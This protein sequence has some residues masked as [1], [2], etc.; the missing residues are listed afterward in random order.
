MMEGCSVCACNENEIPSA[1][2][3]NNLGQLHDFGWVSSDVKGEGS[4]EFLERLNMSLSTSLPGEEVD[5]YLAYL[6]AMDDESK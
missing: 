3:E 1:W 4:G 6:A 5:N 2:R